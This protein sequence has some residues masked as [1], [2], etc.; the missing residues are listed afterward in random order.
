MA[1]T[2]LVRI[3]ENDFKE[4]RMKFPDVKIADFVHMT[5]RTNPFVQVEAI[6][7]RNVKK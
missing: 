4:I 5:T 6:L 3:Y 1:K 2:K 7:R